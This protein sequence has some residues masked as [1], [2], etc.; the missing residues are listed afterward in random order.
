MANPNR[1][2]WLCC[3][4]FL[5]CGGGQSP[6]DPHSGNPGADTSAIE[7]AAPSGG[8]LSAPD[9]AA[10][11]SSAPDASPVDAGE[12]ADSNAGDSSVPGADI[13]ESPG[14]ASGGD[15]TETFRY[16]SQGFPQFRI[17]H[18]LQNESCGVTGRGCVLEVEP[19]H[20]LSAWLESLSR[21]SNLAVLHWDRAI[22][23][24]VFAEECPSNEDCLA[25]YDQRAP[26][27][28]VSWVRGFQEYFD[29]APARYLAVS[30]L[31]GARRGYQPLYQA[32]GAG[33]PMGGDCPDFTPRARISTGGVKPVTVAM[34]DAY[35]RFLGWLNARLRPSHLAIMV[36]ANLLRKNCPQSWPSL[37]AL[38]HYLVD[39]LRQRDPQ[40]KLFATLEYPSLL[41]WNMDACYKLVFASCNSAPGVVTETP[42]PAKCYP[43]DLAPIGELDEGGRLDVLALSFYPDGLT[44]TPPQGP[45]P[46]LK[47][48]P[49][50]WDGKSGCLAHAKY[51]SWVDPL[52][53]LDRLGWSKPI[54]ISEW[55]ARACGGLARI[56][57]NGRLQWIET[58]GNAG[59]QLFWMDHVLRE[60]RK[61]RMPFVVWSFARDY[62]PLPRWVA[63]SQLFDSDVF[64]LFNA[65]PCSG[66]FDKNGADKPPITDLW[67]SGLKR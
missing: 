42:D 17:Q 26:G 47:W 2:W 51:G 11:D 3:T 67:R 4:G 1:L 53:Q 29:K 14:D 58:G 15:K 56:P 27:E 66:V 19:Q 8:G 59:S 43:L 34:A 22:P 21:D 62:D 20:D 33:L 40:V 23:W 24:D 65:W 18:N 30:V 64:S 5:A 10:D 60:A 25:W 54:V 6:A 31:N 61:R 13:G 38:Y 45:A 16:P 55:S 35:L 50:N 12:P 48:Y 9:A 36:E 49:E 39:R 44:M 52:A 63:D 41:G 28:L 46:I 37:V 32:G 7:D 57:V